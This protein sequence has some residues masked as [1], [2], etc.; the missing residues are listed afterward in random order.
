M[1]IPNLS[2]C[3]DCLA[4]AAN[5]HGETDAAHVARYTAAA[6][7]LG[8]LIPECGDNGTGDNGDAECAEYDG[9]GYRYCT[10]DGFRRTPCEYCGDTLAGDR[11][12]ATLAADIPRR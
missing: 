5:G 1:N 4:V 8:E 7:R 3:G 9:H 11:W 6:A 2:V 12:H 10:G